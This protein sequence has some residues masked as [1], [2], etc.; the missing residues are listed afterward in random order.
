MGTEIF[1]NEEKLWPDGVRMIKDFGDQFMDPMQ[2]GTDLAPLESAVLPRDVVREE[3]IFDYTKSLLEVFNNQG[4]T[5]NKDLFTFPYDWRYGV[6]GV[7]ADGSN[8]VG[9]LKQKIKAII[10]PLANFLF[11]LVSVCKNINIIIPKK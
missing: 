10:S 3:V 7:Y 4:Y 1:K 8:N 2:F 11:I 5:E 6:T 9:K